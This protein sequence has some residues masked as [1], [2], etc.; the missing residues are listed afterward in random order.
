MTEAGGEGGGGA[1]PEL[2][3][4]A[5][6]TITTSPSPTAAAATGAALYPP[7]DVKGEKKKK[8]KRGSNI[9]TSGD[10]GDPPTSARIK[11]SGSTIRLKDELTPKGE[12]D[13]SKDKDKEGKDKDKKKRK[14]KSTRS[15]SKERV[16]EGKERS[17]RD[18]DR[19]ARRERLKREGKSPRAS[20]PTSS[21][22]ASPKKQSSNP[23]SPLVN[24]SASPLPSTDDDDEEDDQYDESDDS[25]SEEEM[26][27]L[28]RPTL[29]VLSLP[30]IPLPK[31]PLVDPEQNPKQYVRRM[32]LEQKAAGAR[33]AT[34]SLST[35]TVTESLSP[36]SP[37]RGRSVPDNLRIG[38]YLLD[39]EEREQTLGRRR[40]H[41]SLTRPKFL[42]ELAKENLADAPATP[43]G[44]GVDA[45]RRQNVY[46]AVLRRSKSETFLHSWDYSY[47]DFWD[48]Y[49][50]DKGLRSGDVFGESA[51]VE[52]SPLI[53]KRESV[54]LS[55]TSEMPAER[56]VELLKE[57]LETVFNITPNSISK[58]LCYASDGKVESGT[59]NGLLAELL[60]YTVCNSTYVRQ[61]ILASPYFVED[62]CVIVDKLVDIYGRNITTLGT[63]AEERSELQITLQLRVLDVLQTWITIGYPDL[64]DNPKLLK[65]VGDCLRSLHL[66]ANDPSL[67]KGI[68]ALEEILKRGNQPTVLGTA[69][70]SLKPKVM[71]SDRSFLDFHPLE[72]ARQM[73][74]IEY[75]ML[76]LVGLNEYRNKRFASPEK[77][78]NLAALVDRFNKVSCWVADEILSTGNIK[79]RVVVLTRFIE[80]ADYC[81][82]LKNFS[83]LMAIVSAL[84]RSCITR[85][86]LT[87]KGLPQKSRQTLQR[88]MVLMEPSSNYK[89]YR[90]VL[91]EVPFPFIPFQGVIFVDL[92]FIEENPNVVSSGLINFAK[93]RMISD[94][95]FPLAR[96]KTT[97]YSFTAI[98]E[99]QSLLKSIRFVSDEDL[100]KQSKL[101]EPASANSKE[102][103]PSKKKRKTFTDEDVVRETLGAWKGV[104]ERA[105][106]KESSPLMSLKR[107]TSLLR[108]NA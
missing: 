87:W 20:S 65:H 99:I 63:T 105:L 88:L 61:F 71:R 15:R 69:P 98:P 90:A 13:K 64:A 83:S 30:R 49:E 80:V 42:D 95:L 14:K 39:T 45:E 100:Y 66:M 18:K 4:L 25:S 33:Q 44:T 11:K 50:Y 31:K 16:K 85:L 82:L 26:G 23:A 59:L 94:Q 9:K 5:A 55:S 75:D 103:D 67:K 93:M 101:N 28:L 97:P 79:K 10:E 68:N 47:I 17:E 62:P 2:A 104:D 107:D 1:P 57:E 8:K 56:R 89:N 92:T 48:A 54:M 91:K 6:I 12:K 51:A 29:S 73:T 52:V 40:A 24:R 86:K 108:L 58:H 3:T 84:N 19:E 74:I 81:R 70:P 41:T 43:T 38:Q 35:S 96:L 34:A 77:S 46:R 32:M 36:D 7:L 27:I 102:T 106:K 76:K 37:P 22:P 60:G 53:T 78:P 72:I 21:S